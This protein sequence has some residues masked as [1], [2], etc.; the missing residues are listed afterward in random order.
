MTRQVVVF[1]SRVRCLDATGL[2]RRH[3]FASPHRAVDRG[4]DIG[5]LRRADVI[6]REHGA[7]HAACG[8]WRAVPCP[9]STG[10]WGC[11]HQPLL[12]P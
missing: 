9:V 5:E 7:L 1:T 4:D 10:G 12:D 11:R 3:T 8:A 6:G 2:V